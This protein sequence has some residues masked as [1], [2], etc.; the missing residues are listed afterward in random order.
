M[1]YFRLW[2]E[3][4]VTVTCHYVLLVTNANAFFLKGH[5]PSFRVLQFLQGLENKYLYKI[6]TILLLKL[7]LFTFSPFSYQWR[8]LME[9]QKKHSTL[10]NPKVIS[11]WTF[12]R[13]KNKHIH[14]RFMDHFQCILTSFSLS[15]GLSVVLST[16]FIVPCVYS[17]DEDKL[18]KD[19]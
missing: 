14:F 12:N 18:E 9:I 1:D 19:V 6:F 10:S 7:K 2:I 4:I 3:T 13:R 8:T 5:P 17:V 16:C 11:N 15:L